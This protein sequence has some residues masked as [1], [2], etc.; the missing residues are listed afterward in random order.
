MR[1]PFSPVILPWHED[2]VDEPKLI[3]EFIIRS[4]HEN[5]N[6]LLPMMED[7]YASRK[8]VL[9]KSACKVTELYHWSD[10]PPIRLPWDELPSRCVIKTN[11]WSGDGIF[12]IDD[13]EEAI[14]GVQKDMAINEIYRVVRDYRDQDGNRWSK[15]KIERKLTRLVRRRYPFLYEWAV[16]AIDPR[17]VLVEELLLNKEGCIPDDIKVHCFFGKAGF[18]QYEVG[19]FTSVKQNLHD[20]VSGDCIE[21]T[22]NRKWPPITEIPNLKDFLGD[23]MFG[24]IVETAEQLSID[25]PYVRV[26]LFMVDSEI[27]FGEFTLYPRSGEKQSKEWEEL[28]GRLWQEGLE[29]S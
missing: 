22:E 2:L 8:Y 26:D 19:K 17:G 14:G 9:S 4:M 6:P 23:E 18:I 3:S 12:I 28:G 7:K 5:R 21:Q 15:R 10:K 1:L 24:K 16:R 20:P 29:R 25:V 11:H 27:Y 13:G